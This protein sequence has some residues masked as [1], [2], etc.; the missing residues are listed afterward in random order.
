[1]KTARPKNRRNTL[2]AINVYE[3]ALDRIRFVY[4]HCD[5]V[6][7]SMSGGKDSTT[8]LHLTRLV[9]AE[10]D[11]LPVKVYWLDQEAEWQASEDY[12]RSVFALPD[13]MPY[14]FQ[15]PFRLTNSLS[16]EKNW[17]HV[18]DPAARDQWIRPQAALS[19]KANPLAPHDRFHFL[20]KNLPRCCNV[21]DKKHVAVI[22]GMRI[23]E[24]LIRRYP[25]MSGG[26]HYEGIKW[27]HKHMIGNTRTFWPLWDWLDQDVW[28]CI[29][30]NQLPYNR[31]YDDF[32]KYGLSGKE[33][34][35]SSL[36]HETAWKAI[37]RLQVIDPKIYDRYVNR[38][39]GVSTFGHWGDVVPHTL[40]VYFASWRD[41]RDYLLVHLIEPEHQETF[42]HRWANQTDEGWC[43][44]HCAEIA[45]N[46]IDGT[47]NM[48]EIN[49]R[50]MKGIDHNTRRPPPP[51]S[52]DHGLEIHPA[53]GARARP[54]AARARGANP[55]SGGHPRPNPQRPR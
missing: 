24:S 46:D 14:W 52:Y 11:R 32:Y 4:D 19:I 20:V 45:V 54:L 41:Y 26:G 43:R 6:V 13:V 50:R 7:V 55:A 48:S 28:A 17:L 3:A 5:D 10:R 21:A 12:M 30:K 22:V 8:I 53:A 37:T 34:R 2:L 31:V 40:P 47:K 38:L 35:V 27:C 23:A 49:T 39:A 1:M 51:S 15:I 36:I 42:R 25:L 18:W 16:R 33:M 9:A 29:A 44:E